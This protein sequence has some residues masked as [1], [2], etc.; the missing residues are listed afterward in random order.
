[1]RQIRVDLEELKLKFENLN[2]TSFEVSKNIFSI[3]YSAFFQPEL[4]VTVKILKD[5]QPSECYFVT[6]VKNYGKKKE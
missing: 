2:L 5:L 4:L 1:M 3:I 6:Y